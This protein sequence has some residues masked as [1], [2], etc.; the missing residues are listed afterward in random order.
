MSALNDPSDRV[1]TAAQLVFLP[2][3]ALWAYELGKLEHDLANV[4]LRKMEELVKAHPLFWCRASRFS[5]T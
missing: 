4:L 3:F 1:V 5:S 2:S